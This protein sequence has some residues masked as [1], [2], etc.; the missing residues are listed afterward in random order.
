MQSAP[1]GLGFS[2]LDTSDFG[3]AET[4]IQTSV[5][6]DLMNAVFYD[7]SVNLQYRLP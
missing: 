6:I 2:G 3:T 4:I 1:C 7:L 5:S